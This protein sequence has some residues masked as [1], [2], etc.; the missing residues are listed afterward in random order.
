MNS[1]RFGF[2]SSMTLWFPWSKTHTAK[3]EEV[4]KALLVRWAETQGSSFEIEAI[5]LFLFVDYNVN[6]VLVS[7]ITTNQQITL[8][9]CFAVLAFTSFSRELSMRMSQTFIEPFSPPAAKRKG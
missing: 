2:D 6:S 1:E 4:H 3:F 5:L 9:Y 7:I 8:F